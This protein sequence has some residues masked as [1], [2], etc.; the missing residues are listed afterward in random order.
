MIT[1]L[2][3]TGDELHA[4]GRAQLVAHQAGRSLFGEPHQVIQTWPGSVAVHSAQPGGG[5]NRRC[6]WCSARPTSPC[7]AAE[8]CGCLVP[9]SDPDC[10]AR[11]E[12]RADPARGV[13]APRRS[14]SWHGHRHP[15][16]LHEDRCMLRMHLELKHSRLRRDLETLTLEELTGMHGPEPGDDD[17][18]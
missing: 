4:I 7:S 5:L 10:G 12:V 1:V 6:V 16:A 15:V 3:E 8:H 18:R 11:P 13:W 2:A 17:G 14:R 9:C